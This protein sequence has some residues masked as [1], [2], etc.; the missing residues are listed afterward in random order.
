MYVSHL[1]QT[2]PRFFPPA[3]APLLMKD[4]DGNKN[5]V[6]DECGFMENNNLIG[7]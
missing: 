7:P 3:E 6:A 5:K 1:D 2:C 4:G